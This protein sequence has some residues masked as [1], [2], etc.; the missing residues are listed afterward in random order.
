MPKAEEESSK[1][2]LNA[3]AMYTLLQRLKKIESKDLNGKIKKSP[4]KPQKIS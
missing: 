1:S 4:E 3:G 2:Q